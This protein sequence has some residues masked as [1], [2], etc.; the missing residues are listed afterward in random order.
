M[1][2]RT[3]VALAAVF[4]A[5]GF[6]FSSNVHTAES[7]P[8]AESGAKCAIQ[9]FDKA[10]EQSKAV[11]VGEV[12]GEEKSGDVRSFDFKVERYWK[13]ADAKNVRIHV[14]ETARFQ[15]WVKKGGR[16]LI[17]APEDVDGKLRVYRCSR[18]RGVDFAEEDLQK[19][20]EGKI[21]R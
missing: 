21:P 16:Y 2:I 4:S 17:Y 18:S 6:G 19:L 11:F 12:A 14:Y 15:A 9:S 1:K 8:R 13:G 7:A 5:I 3:I 10:F 20:G